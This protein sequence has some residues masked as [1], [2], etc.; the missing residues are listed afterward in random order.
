MTDTVQPQLGGTFRSTE[1]DFRIGRVFSQAFSVLS[2]NLLPF[3]IVTAIAALPYLLIMDNNTR[4]AD[5]GT[6]AGM[7]VL[8][9]IIMMVLNALSQAIILYAAFEDMRGRS[10][11]MVESLRVGLSRFL[12]VIGTALLVGLLTM[13]AG[14]AL[15]IPAFIVMAML[16]VAMPACV[17]E[18]LGPVASLGRS[19]DLT[20][21]NRWKIFG[22]WILVF[23]VG[24]IIQTM[25]TGLATALGGRLVGE[26]VLLAWTAV[27][28]AFSAVVA[29]VAYRDLRVAK[30]GVNTD[31]IASVFD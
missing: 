6:R 1:N 3:C 28:G 4:I 14:L 25:L 22:L 20:K 15:V 21:G 23:V 29:V 8:G 12:P 11:N 13:L 26:I 30:E 31:Q 5:S 17:V 2:R 10:A 24:A 18:R 16:F 9:F 7:S 19:A 27:F